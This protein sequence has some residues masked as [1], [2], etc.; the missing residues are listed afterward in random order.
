MLCILFLL[1]MSW[2]SDLYFCDLRFVA[3]IALTLGCLLVRLLWWT[4]GFR[5]L[6]QLFGVLLLDLPFMV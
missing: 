6:L 1:T 5:L 2:H 4:V 3:A